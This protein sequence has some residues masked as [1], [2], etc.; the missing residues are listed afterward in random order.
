[1]S[2]KL[3]SS[4]I[5]TFGKENFYTG[6]FSKLCEC[7]ELIK[8]EFDIFEYPR[9]ILNYTDYREENCVLLEEPNYE[10]YFKF[11]FCKYYILKNNKIEII[12]KEEIEENDIVAYLTITPT[13]P[14]DFEW[15]FYKK[16]NNE[17]ILL[18]DCYNEYAVMYMKRRNLK[19][20][21]KQLV[22]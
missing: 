17:L 6:I 2:I 15:L 19:I 7:G 12:L 9:E 10:E 1:M 3:D 21:L 8:L 11:D 22:S 20:K 13:S 5:R 18:E 4:E 14:P 16:I